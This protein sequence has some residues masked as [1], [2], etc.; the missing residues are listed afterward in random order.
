MNRRDALKLLSVLPATAT[1]RE[2]RAEPG[3]VIV[4]TFPGPVPRQHLDNLKQFAEQA[5]PDFRFMV[6]GDGGTVSVLRKS[7]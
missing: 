2:L 5:F 4:I 1:I 7:L 3:D 6:L